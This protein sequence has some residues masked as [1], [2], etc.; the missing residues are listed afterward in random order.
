MYRIIKAQSDIEFVAFVQSNLQKQSIFAGISTKELMKQM[1]RVKS[2]NIWSY[3]IN[4]HDR[5]DK[6]GNVLVQFKNPNGGPGDVYIYYDVPVNVYRKWHSA[7]S[8]GHYFWRYLRNNY[9]Y[10]KLTGDKKGKLPNAIN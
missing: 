10:S 1:V 2:S 3:T 9:K 4:T 8:K 5:K 7:T 6:T